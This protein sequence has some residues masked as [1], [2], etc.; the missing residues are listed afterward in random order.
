MEKLGV[1]KVLYPMEENY[2]KT[3]LLN[4]IMKDMGE[5][6]EYDFCLYAKDDAVDGKKVISLDIPEDAEISGVV[7]AQ[8]IQKDNDKCLLIDCKPMEA[9]THFRSEHLKG[10]QDAYL[11]DDKNDLVLF[12]NRITLEGYYLQSEPDEFDVLLEN[13]AANSQNTYSMFLR[14][15]QETKSREF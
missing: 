6:P 4:Y 9:Y 12:G 10:N 7:I 13:I 1:T 14:V 2:S 15:L 11:V 5:N 8:E 3:V